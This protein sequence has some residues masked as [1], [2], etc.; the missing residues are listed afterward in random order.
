M[1][2]SPG[3]VCWGSNQDSG[4]STQGCHLFNPSLCFTP[5]TSLPVV[6]TT[7]QFTSH[8]KDIISGTSLCLQIFPEKCSNQLPPIRA[9]MFISGCANMTHI[10]SM[11]K[12]SGDQMF[13]FTVPVLSFVSCVPADFNSSTILFQPRP[14]RPVFSFFNNTPHKVASHSRL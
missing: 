6:M 7:R 10:S 1:F 2:R 13:R 11:Y 14:R 4:W 3:D 9:N 8:I 5:Y 12:H